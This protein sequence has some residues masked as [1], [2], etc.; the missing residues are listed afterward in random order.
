MDL[1]MLSNFPQVIQHF[2]QNVVVK[3]DPDR[4]LHANS[5]GGPLMEQSVA[6]DIQTCG[7]Y[8]LSLASDPGNKQ[9]IKKKGQKQIGLKPTEKNLLS[10]LPVCFQNEAM[11]ILDFEWDPDDVENEDYLPDISDQQTPL[12][13]LLSSENFK[14]LHDI[15]ED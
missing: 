14:L 6:G 1:L 4:C 9:Y 15:L 12:D 8:H 2:L 5:K 3:Q 7:D 13:R 10:T 11:E